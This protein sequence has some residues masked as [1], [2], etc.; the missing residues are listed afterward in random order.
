VVWVTGR[1]AVRI[2]IFILTLTLVQIGVVVLYAN[3]A[4]HAGYGNQEKLDET[5]QAR[6]DRED[7]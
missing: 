5:R 7:G 4:Q 6:Q 3:F 2:N 1:M